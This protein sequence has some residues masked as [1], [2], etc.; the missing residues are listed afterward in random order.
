[1]AVAGKSESGG[2]LP[3]EPAAAATSSI[4]DSTVRID[5]EEFARL[6]AESRERSE[7]KDEE[8]AALEH[9][10][11]IEREE[12]AEREVVHRAW[13]EQQAYVNAV[14]DLKKKVGWR[15]SR[16]ARAIAAAILVAAVALGVFLYSH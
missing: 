8:R 9:D 7:A 13:R 14:A 5:A 11:R 15:E 6:A 10:V 1:M 2:P 4:E 16:R 3:A 12:Q